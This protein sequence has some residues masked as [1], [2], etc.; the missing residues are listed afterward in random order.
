MRVNGHVES[1]SQRCIQTFANSET[2]FHLLN[3]LSTFFSITLKKGG[4]K[5]ERFVF[6]FKS[7]FSRF[8]Y[9]R[10]CIFWEEMSS[11]SLRQR[12]SAKFNTNRA[13]KKSSTIF[14]KI[15]TCVISWQKTF[16]V[17][18]GLIQSICGHF[19]ITAR[20]PST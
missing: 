1:K 2:T 16:L 4:V 17:G 5:I 10:L 9:L 19:S 3:Q 8:Q 14:D 12:I 18:C 20:N 7:V 15:C 13:D 11:D 6:S